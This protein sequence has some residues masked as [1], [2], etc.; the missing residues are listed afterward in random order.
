MI[1]DLEMLWMKENEMKKTM[2]VELL[3][4]KTERDLCATKQ[5]DAE[6]KLRDLERLWIALEWKCESD[7]QEYQKQYIWEWDTERWEFE[8]KKRQLDEDQYMFNLNKDRFLSSETEKNKL[9]KEVTELWNERDK[10]LYSMNDV[11]D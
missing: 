7:I 5:R 8:A 4:I 2:E 6:L 10:L 9:E 11:K 3:T 1:T